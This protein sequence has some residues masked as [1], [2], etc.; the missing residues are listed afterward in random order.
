MKITVTAED[1]KRGKRHSCER[2][3]VALAISRV[4]RIRGRVW[5]DGDSCEA[6]SGQ[7][8]SLPKKVRDFVA[9][10]DDLESVRPFSFVMRRIA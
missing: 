1:I 8:A 3:P 4:L 7:R 2:C 9:A 5:V 6:P 10:F